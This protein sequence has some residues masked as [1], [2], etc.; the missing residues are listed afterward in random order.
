MIDRTKLYSVAFAA[1]LTCLFTLAPLLHGQGAPSM[2]I[3]GSVPTRSE[4]LSQA[5]ALFQEP[6]HWSEA[7]DLLVSAARLRAPGDP[8]KAYI[9]A[10]AARLYAYSGNTHRALYWMQEAGAQALSGGDVITAADTYTQAAHLAAAQRDWTKVKALAQK[11]IALSA[12]PL[13]TS[14]QRFA[15]R[16]PF[17]RQAVTVN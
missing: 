13:L 3:T 11:V 17:E 8:E 2:R 12:S 14:E 6:A 9:L 1:A 15:M 7:A 16:L 5:Q 4:S 10:T